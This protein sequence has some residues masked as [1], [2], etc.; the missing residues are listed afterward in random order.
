VVFGVQKL[1]FVFFLNSNMLV[2]QQVD[3]SEK[4]RQ[5]TG[6]LRIFQQSL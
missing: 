6:A 3:F 5:Q 2:Y 1:A 4:S